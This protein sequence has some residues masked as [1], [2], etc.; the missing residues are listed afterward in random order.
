MTPLRML[1]RLLRVATVLLRYRLDELVDATR[2]YR[3]LKLLRPLL[4]RARADVRALPRGARLRG[5]LNVL[6]PILV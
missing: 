5:A 4:P 1:P 3:P 6:G 2:L